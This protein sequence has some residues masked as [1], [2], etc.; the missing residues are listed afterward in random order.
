VE[1]LE[2]ASDEETGA[3]FF[4]EYADL[5]TVTKALKEGGWSVTSAEVGYR[6]KEPM[7]LAGEARTEVEAFLAAIDDHD[8]VHRVY[9]ALS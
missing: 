1:P 8:D 9:A 7:A 4:T 5:D 3:R 2:S 6:S